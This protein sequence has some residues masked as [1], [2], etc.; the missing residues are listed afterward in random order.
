MAELG[1]ARCATEH[2]LYMRRRGKEELI[3]GVCVDDLIV[4]G[5]REED[6]AKFKVEMAAWFKMSNSGAL[7]LPRH[8]GEAGEGHGHAEAARL[9]TEAAGAGQDGRLQG[10]SDTDGGA[11][12]ALEAKCGEGGRHALP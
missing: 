3:V 8:R 10:R 2:A 11:D 5:A 9:R 1:F 12:Q 4:T 7:V 6:I